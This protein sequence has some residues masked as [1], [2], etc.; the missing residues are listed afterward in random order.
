MSKVKKTFAQLTPLWNKK[1]SEDL[2]NFNKICVVDGQVLDIT[3]TTCCVLGEAHGFKYRWKENI[4][5]PLYKNERE[6]YKEMGF[7]PTGAEYSL[8]GPGYC[9]RCFELSLAFTRIADTGT[10]AEQ[11]KRFEKTKTDLEDHFFEKHS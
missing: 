3:N 8:N 9:E 10:E 11:K 7:V 5:A 4:E 2:N 6:C 1:I